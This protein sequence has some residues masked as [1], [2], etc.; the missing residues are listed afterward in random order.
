MGLPHPFLQHTGF[1][2]TLTSTS[3]ARA[4]KAFIREDFPTLLL[5]IKHTLYKEKED[6]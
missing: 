6:N 1:L 5:P 2:E 3:G 4:N